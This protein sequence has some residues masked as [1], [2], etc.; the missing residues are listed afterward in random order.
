MLFNPFHPDRLSH[1]ICKGLLINCLFSDAFI[2]LKIVLTTNYQAWS[3]PGTF[4]GLCLPLWYN[5]YFFYFY[6]VS[7]IDACQQSPCQNGGT[8][9]SS[10]PGTF[11]CVCPPLWN[12][13]FCTVCK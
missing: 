4:Q 1:I 8:C 12:G 13:Q 11:Q 9:D 2:A 10:G 7:A 5:K 6:Y 3:G